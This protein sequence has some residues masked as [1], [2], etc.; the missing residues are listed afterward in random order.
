M[1]VRYR[2]ARRWYF[3]SPAGRL[4]Y[5]CLRVLVLVLASAGPAP[6]PPPPPRPQ[7]VELRVQAK[8]GSEEL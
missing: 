3:A 2:R 8:K 5:R 6:P 7:T 1:V 4:I